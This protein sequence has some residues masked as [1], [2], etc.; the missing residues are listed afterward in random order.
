MVSFKVSAGA[1]A[2]NESNTAG[3]SSQARVGGAASMSLKTTQD[4]ARSARSATKTLK[5]DLPEGDAKVGAVR[6]LPVVLP[7]TV[8]WL[9][10]GRLSSSPSTRRPR[11]TW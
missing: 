4:R 5:I 7:V 3:G 8:I 11:D 1:M 10:N 6:E 2:E 9:M